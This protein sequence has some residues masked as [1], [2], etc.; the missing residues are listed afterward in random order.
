MLSGW[1]A[2]LLAM[3]EPMLELAR[4]LYEVCHGNPNDAKRVLM[5]IRDHGAVYEAAQREID[6]RLEVVRD[7]QKPP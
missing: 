5:R 6:R 2:F 7:K 3:R 4:E 1:V